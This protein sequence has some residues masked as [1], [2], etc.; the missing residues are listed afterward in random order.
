MLNFIHELDIPII[1]RLKKIYANLRVYSL[2]AP[3]K[4]NDHIWVLTS[5]TE[6]VLKT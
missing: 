4:T 3:A 2:Q 1:A 5:L 6:F